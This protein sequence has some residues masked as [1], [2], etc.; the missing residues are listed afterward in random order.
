MPGERYA[1]GPAEPE[2]RCAR[3]GRGAA[4]RRRWRPSRRPGGRAA[5]GARS[6]AVA[7]LARA[8]DAP[9]RAGR[10]RVSAG[11]RRP[12]D[13]LRPSIGSSGPSPRA[14]PRRTPAR[15]RDRGRRIPRL[16]RAPAAST[17][18][19]RRGPTCGPTSADLGDG[20][21]PL[22][23]RPAARGDPL[24]PSLGGA[25]GP[26]AGRPVGRHRDAAPAAPPAAGPRGRR[27]RR[28][29]WRSSTSRARRAAMRTAAT[30]RASRLALALRDRALVETAYAAGLRISELAAAE[31]GALDLRRGEIRVIGKGRK[32]RIG[33]LGRPG[34]RR[35]MERLPRR[36]P[37]GPARAAVADDRDAPPAAGLPEPPRR[38]ARRARPA[39]PPRPAV[40][41]RRAAGR[42]LARTRCA[43]R[44]RRTCS[45]A[46]PT[47]ASSR[48]CSAT[49]AWRR[50]RSTRT[51]RRRGC[52]PP[53]GRPTR[54]R[55]A[56]PLRDRRPA[57][58]GP[59]R[60]SSSRA[61]SS[62]RACSAGSGRRHRQHVRALAG[63]R[64]VLRRVPHPGPDLPARRG[65]GAVVGADPDRL[66]PVRDRRARPRAWRVVSTVVNLMLIALAVLGRG[67]VRPRP[68][69]SSRS[70][71]PGFDAGPARHDRSS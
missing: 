18:G 27:G 69:R 49:R 25:R 46:A 26:R 54:G 3:P 5:A 1:G 12:R 51:S 71:R 38:A 9:G 40:P 10:R 64:R 16:A 63:A 21:C 35:R 14:T 30:A 15:L 13:P 47:C 6:S 67:R 41:P 2:P 22:V 17:G 70:S 32:E 43:T 56:T 29:C 45:T 37:A 66:G 62:C 50:P 44:S 48:S 65:R 31:L 33:L 23:G 60:D 4:P 28:G 19:A 24:V 55:A 8:S 59:G 20:P 36:R 68:G 53:T 34:A 11:R 7:W 61:R 57:H 52:G 39:L 58:P 42:G